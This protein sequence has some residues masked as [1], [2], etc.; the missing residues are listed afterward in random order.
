M[1]EPTNPIEA[2]RVAKMTEKARCMFTTGGYSLSLLFDAGVPGVYLVCSPAG[3]KY[4]VD[5]N[6]PSCSCPDFQ[7]RGKTCKHL[8]GVELELVRQEDEWYDREANAELTACI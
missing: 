3:A 7:E 4:N 8:I 1:Y 5:L 6:K 2:L